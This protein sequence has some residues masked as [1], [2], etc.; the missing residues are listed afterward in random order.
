MKLT[1]MLSSIMVF[2]INLFIAARMGMNKERII[3]KM[4][5]VNNYYL[6]TALDNMPLN[7]EATTTI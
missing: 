7:M 4:K 3:T 5:V 6:E 1:T 2:I